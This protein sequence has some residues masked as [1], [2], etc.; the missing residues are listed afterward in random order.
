MLGIEGVKAFLFMLVHD[1]TPQRMEDVGNSTPVGVLSLL[2]FPRIQGWLAVNR[3]RHSR[4][5]MSQEFLAN[6]DVWFIIGLYLPRSALV[7]QAPQV[8]RPPPTLCYATSHFPPATQVQRSIVL[9]FSKRWRQSN[10]RLL[11]RASL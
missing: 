11:T 5:D 6:I 1:A 4:D 2:W 3:T 7:Q 9:Q 8:D 10:R